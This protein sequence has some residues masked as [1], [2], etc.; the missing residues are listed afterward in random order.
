[1]STI[2]LFIAFLSIIGF[3]VGLVNPALLTPL[4]KKRLSR[5]KIAAIFILTFL[6]AAIVNGFVSPQKA[7]HAQPAAQIVTQQSTT[8]VQTPTSTKAPT[9]TPTQKP[10]FT[11][12]GTNRYTAIVNNR[13]DTNI[14]KSSNTNANT[15]TNTN[16]NPN[17]TIYT[18]D[19]YPNTHCSATNVNEH[20]CRTGKFS[21]R[22]YK[23]IGASRSN[24]VMQRWIV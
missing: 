20:E 6:A 16:S 1:M 18:S 15:K 5:G 17:D 11:T 13:S 8:I 21:N 9:P 19:C 24:R 22:L 7:Q 23:R 10:T 2:L 14:Y 4:F 3:V 12:S